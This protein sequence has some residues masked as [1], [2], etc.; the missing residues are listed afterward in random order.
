MIPWLT[1]GLIAGLL[2]AP[3]AQARPSISSLDAKLDLIDGKVD[4]LLATSVSGG[5]VVPVTLVQRVNSDNEPEDRSGDTT[6]TRLIC[7]GVNSCFNSDSGLTNR[8]LQGSDEVLVVTSITALLFSGGL[9]PA[10]GYGL[11]NFGACRT[12]VFPRNLGIPT[13]AV[14]G[15]NTAHVTLRPGVILSDLTVAERLC[16]TSLGQSTADTEVTLH[17]YLTSRP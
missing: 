13:V 11:L 3:L 1:A 5:G 9:P 6:V 15:R 16:F 17:G 4:A 12:G 7:I 8:I 2:A 10:D 14:N